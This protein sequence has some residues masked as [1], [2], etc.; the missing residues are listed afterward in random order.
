MNVS[1]AIILYEGQWGRTLSKEA[2]EKAVR[3]AVYGDCSLK[4]LRFVDPDMDVAFEIEVAVTTDWSD[5]EHV[6]D[7][8]IERLL[9]R[10]EPEYE[11]MVE[12]EVF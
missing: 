8:I 3:R 7:R 6:R 4:E 9:A 2:V 1:C 10:F 11:S 5:E 12:V